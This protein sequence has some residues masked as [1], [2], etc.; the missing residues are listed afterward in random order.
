[1]VERGGVIGGPSAGAT[2]QGDYL[3]RGAIAG[4]K[5]MMAPEPEHQK[6]FA[7]LRKSAIDQHL[8]TRN[9][10]DDL[11][12]VMKKL[13]KFIGIGLS[14]ATA[15]VV[16]GDR[17]EVMGKW[18][19]TI[20]DGTRVHEPWQKSYFVLSAGDVHN[21]RTRRVEKFGIGDQKPVAVRP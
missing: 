21:I 14:E 19:V 18:K 2:I 1:M 7:F 5:I 13:P 12:P 3:V 8:N 10:W 11:I 15:I 4:P 6:A 9:R 17:F 16:T 20:H